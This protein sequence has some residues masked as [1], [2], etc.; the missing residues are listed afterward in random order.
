VGVR[1]NPD[2]ELTR[3]QAARRANVTVAVVDAWLARGW[4]DLTGVHHTLTTR[5]VGRTRFIRHG[6]VLRAERDTRLKADRS[7]RRLSFD[8]TAA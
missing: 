8:D 3:T 2:A 6:D 1:L 5:K 7:H 4:Y